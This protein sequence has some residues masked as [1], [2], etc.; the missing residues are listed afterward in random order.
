MKRRKECIVDTGPTT[1]KTR[2]LPSKP[3]YQIEQLT[4]RIVYNLYMYALKRKKIQKTKI[5]ANEMTTCV[6]QWLVSGNPP[7][8]LFRK[9]TN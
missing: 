8:F 7:T 1:L 3:S 6:T 5:L 2:T 9:Y 4:K